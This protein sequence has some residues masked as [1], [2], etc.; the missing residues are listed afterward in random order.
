M[1]QPFARC[2][3]QN[4]LC[5]MIYENWGFTGSPFQTTSLPPSELGE[6]LLVGRGIE[7]GTLMR[8]L[9]SPPKLATLEGLNGVG[10]TSVVNIASF[11]LFSD[12]KKTG[13]GAL[14]IPCRRIFN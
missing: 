1:Q 9:S 6:K 5:K 8:R 10:K 7:L 3:N 2:N 13:N 14:Y 11:K 4:R 12:Y